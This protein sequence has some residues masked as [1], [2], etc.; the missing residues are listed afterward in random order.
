[1]GHTTT[2]DALSGDN[3]LSDTKT[4]QLTCA[5]LAAEALILG[6][7]TG[8]DTVTVHSSRISKICEDIQDVL[9][10]P[11]ACSTI[12]TVPLDGCGLSAWY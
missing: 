9:W 11:D 1:M 6:S 5:V 2:D 10:G 3:S 12:T 7:C 4:Y 8:S